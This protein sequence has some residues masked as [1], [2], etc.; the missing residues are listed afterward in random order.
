MFVRNNESNLWENPSGAPLFPCSLCVQFTCAQCGANLGC[1]GPQMVL[2]LSNKCHFGCNWCYKCPLSHFYPNQSPM[3]REI[4]SPEAPGG[5]ATFSQHNFWSK[6]LN[7]GATHGHLAQSA[8]A[9]V[10]VILPP[11]LPS[12]PPS[13]QSHHLL[14]LHSPF[15]LSHH[16][17]LTLHSLSLLSHLLSLSILFLSSFP[18][19]LSLSSHFLSGNSFLFSCLVVILFGT[20]PIFASI[21]LFTYLGTPYFQYG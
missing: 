18:Q 20:T 10:F 15:L 6:L 12:L 14:S 5:V 9:I 7:C 8:A 11:S 4:V 13:S 16:L 2:A 19:L 21:T 3:P 17:S 1:R